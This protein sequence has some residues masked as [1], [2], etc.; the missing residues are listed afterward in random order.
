MAASLLLYRAEYLGLLD[1]TLIVG[2]LTESR[3]R[4]L[5]NVL[6]AHGIASTAALRLAS[7]TAFE[8]SDEELA[9]LL[10]L[11]REQVADSPLPESEWKPMRE[12]LGD[13]LLATLLDVSATS[14]RRYAEGERNTPDSVATRLHTLAM[15]TSD[16]AGGYNEI[17]M[18]RWF[19]R[20]RPQLDG[21]A[22]IDLL[23]GGFD[24]DSDDVQRVRDLAAWLVGSGSAA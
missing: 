16:L 3:V 19:Q 6:A 15:I 17:G 4:S 20:A 24:P 10:G 14:L 23:A 12:A 22:P 1:A 5:V 7:P 8:V 11:V 13:E 21:R 2:P 9:S 18:R